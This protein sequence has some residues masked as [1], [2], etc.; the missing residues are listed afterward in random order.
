MVRKL[1][2]FV[3]GLVVASSAQAT[4]VMTNFHPETQGLHFENRLTRD[5]SVADITWP[6][7]CGGFA[8]TAL[9]Y[10]DAHKPVPKQDWCPA[11]GTVL[12]QYIWG[13]QA[14]SVASNV[15]KWLEV[16]NN[17]SG[18]RDTE[19]F[20]W[21]LQTQAGSRID[22]LK[23]YI[24][25][26]QPVP[27][28]LKGAGGSG[29]HQVL[30]IGYDMGRYN[31]T[32]PQFREDFKIFI[33]NPNFPNRTTVLQPVVAERIYKVVDTADKYRT[34]FVNRNYHPK[35]PPTIPNATYPNDGKIHSLVLTFD[36]GGD[37]MRGDGANV[38]VTINGLDGSQQKFS[39]VNMGQR[40][41]RQYSQSIEFVLRT[42]ILESQ[43]KSIDLFHSTGGG[44]NPDNWDMQSLHVRGIGGNV[45]VNMIYTPFHRFT[46]TNKQFTVSIHSAPPT[47]RNMVGSL[48]LIFQTGG[49]DLRGGNDNLDI[50]ITF[51]DN[52]F[53]QFDNVNKRA[54]WGNNTKSKVD[55][56]FNRP[57][58]WNGV[59][60]VTLFKHANGDNWNMDS[61]SV[62]ANY[63]GRQF[64]ISR[65]AYNRFTGDAPSLAFDVR[66]NM[67][68]PLGPPPPGG[69]S[70]PKKKGG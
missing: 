70:P 41:I 3:V 26:G 9:D 42:P 58:R 2:G 57:H 38:D 48:T 20:N 15:D 44:L 46:D 54:N 43:V 51:D 33:Y 8:Y 5:L 37:D 34:W 62:L 35:V 16:M 52:S 50:V 29:D 23:Q 7:Y 13:R 28:G 61:V 63:G 59:R 4:P 22:E 17:P 11:T 18:A 67:I 68:D 30:A 56:A 31:G 10:F 39:N 32:N 14:E 53:Q 55:L 60:R 36:T 47:P 40:W 27:I 24:D 69:G 6:G 66:M 64:E 1:I 65:H 25:R 21:G 45:D 12:E 19:F 49:D